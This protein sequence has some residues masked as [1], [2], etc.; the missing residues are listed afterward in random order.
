MN[1]F[2]IPDEIGKIEI[3]YHN[4]DKPKISLNEFLN[5]QNPNKKRVWIKESDIFD[6]I[7]A[8]YC[9]GFDTILRQKRKLRRKNIIKEMKKELESLFIIDSDY[10]IFRTKEAHYITGT[11][12]INKIFEFNES[13]RKDS[14]L[15]IEIV[16]ICK[17]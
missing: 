8:G 16:E 3:I 1:N 13:E 7:T 15:Q 5:L 2:Y 6:E 4:S 12:N 17:I 14:Y 10:L 11:K 9:F